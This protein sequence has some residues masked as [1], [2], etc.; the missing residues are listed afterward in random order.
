MRPPTLLGHL[1]AWTLGALGVVWVGFLLIGLQTGLH[2]ADELTDGHLASTAS[3]LLSQQGTV[4]FTAP[5]KADPPTPDLKNHD[6]QQSMSVMVWNGRGELLT[7]TG[8]APVPP[9]ETEEGFSTQQLGTPPQPWRAFAKW[10]GPPHGRRVMVL[11]S[12]EE[13]DDLAWDIAQQVAEPGLWLLPVVALALGL[14]IRRGLRPLGT[15]SKDVAQ[16]DIR[17]GEPLPAR[18]RHAEFSAVVDSINALVERYQAAMS[19]ERQLAGELAHELRTP[20]ASLT[21]H[22]QSLQGDLPAGE[23]AHATERL[24]TEALRA[25]QVLQHLLA[26]ARASH[27]ELADAAVPLD[28]VPLAARVMADYAQV[29]LDR[30]VDLSLSGDASLPVKG[31]EV[32]LEMALR[33]LVENALGHAPADSAVEVH[34]DAGDRFIEVTNA[35]G[36]RQP[37]GT[38]GRL[39]MGLGHRVIDKVAAVHGAAFTQ[40]TTG[41]DACSYRITFPAP[42]DA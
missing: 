3:L 6:Y 37:D 28:A 2:E 11:L 20:L 19:R 16:M 31:H 8:D 21:L 41:P 35:T 7:R 25:G 33:N 38:S 40:V 32:L 30:R 36:E 24:A 9:F 5:R 22:A 27:T 10:D 42:V 29:A 4:P 26:L 12:V 1:L 17:H 23:R 18:Q 15:L 14:A 39:G 34:V 13:R